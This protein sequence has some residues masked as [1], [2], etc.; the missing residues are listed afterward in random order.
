LIDRDGGGV[1]GNVGF[2]FPGGPSSPPLIEADLDTPL[3]PDALKAKGSS[4]GTASLFVV[5]RSRDPRDLA[6]ALSAFFERESCGQCP[7]CVRGTESLHKIA[8]A[9][10]SGT[11]RTQDVADVGEIAGFMAMHGYCAHCR[12]AAWAMTRLVSQ[13]EPR[14]PVEAEAPR[15]PSA[16]YDPFAAGSPERAAI[17]AVLA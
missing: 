1:P 10:R 9:L 15:P 16:A 17:E 13:T 11:A 2:V 4:L 6:V 14:M 8:R 7:P 5:A 12:A 3:H